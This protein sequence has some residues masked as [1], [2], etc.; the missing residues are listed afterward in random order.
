LKKEKTNWFKMCSISGRRCGGFKIAD[1]WP[2]KPTFTRACL[3]KH[4]GLPTNLPK[5]PNAYRRWVFVWTAKN[6]KTPAN[7]SFRTNKILLRPSSKK[8]LQVRVPFKKFLN[9]SW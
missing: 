4:E 9:W 8:E 5:P 3:V 7:L 6:Q 1:I 2:N